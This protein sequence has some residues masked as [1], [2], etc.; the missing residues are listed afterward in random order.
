MYPGLI[1]VIALLLVGCSR[2][3]ESAPTTAPPGIRPA[4]D[5]TGVALQQLTQLLRKYS[6][7][8]Q[9]APASLREVVSEDYLASLPPPPAGKNYGFDPKRLEAILVAQ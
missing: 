4:A 8:N 3:Q 5:A 9:H 2:H 6:A 7:A 1:L